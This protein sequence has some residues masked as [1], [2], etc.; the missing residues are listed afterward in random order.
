MKRTSKEWMRKRIQS[1][2]KD[3]K[4]ILMRKGVFPKACFFQYGVSNILTVL[5]LTI[6]LSNPD[7]YQFLP[8]CR[9]SSGADE[10]EGGAPSSAGPT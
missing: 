2:S 4:I 3:R 10:Q 1:R 7:G 9:K 8:S 6:I 5:T